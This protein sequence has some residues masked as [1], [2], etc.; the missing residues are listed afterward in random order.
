MNHP[1]L[2]SS[3]SFV[4]L[5]TACGGGGGAAPEAESGADTSTSGA[6]SSSE[7]SAPASGVGEVAPTHGAHLFGVYIVVAEAGSFALEAA[8]ENLR[9]RGI[10]H[11]V[12]EVGCDQGASEAL[13]VPP[14]AH[15]V[16]VMF[17][18]REAAE[19]YA[20]S[21]PTSP[22]GIAEVTVGCAD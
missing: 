14:D 8:A 15:G 10:Q 1:L 20:A 4:L 6:E 21:L 9:T 17:T 19:A 13:G 5:L 16:S 18:T 22:T 11:S 12:G 7:S 2:S 3:F